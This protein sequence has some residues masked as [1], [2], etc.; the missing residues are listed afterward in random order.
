M[1]LQL[2]DEIL[3][4][5]QEISL[6]QIKLEKAEKENE[7]KKKENEE[8]EKESEK[9][10]SEKR[11]REK[12]K[13]EKEKN[14]YW[15][16]FNNEVQ[17]LLQNYF[18]GLS[19]FQKNEFEANLLGLVKAFKVSIEAVGKAELEKTKAALQQNIAA[20]NKAQA[21]KL[22]EELAAKNT[23][24]EA[25]ATS[26][27]QITELQKELAAKITALQQEKVELATRKD[28]IAKL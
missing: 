26:E 23:A 7:E 8:K 1:T 22:E 6:L 10:K 16:G 13:R 4:L 9:R 15:D 19:D 25:Q 21:A 5:D 27:A 11:K 28:Q 2:I 20:T 12:R 3:N 14:N 17:G 24:L 18:G